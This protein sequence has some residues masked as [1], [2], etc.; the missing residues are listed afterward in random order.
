MSSDPL[1]DEELFWLK[2]VPTAIPS[3]VRVVG[4]I[5][6]GSDICRLR[7]NDSQICKLLRREPADQCSSLLLS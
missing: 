5:L 4:A 3:E 2:L 6:V 7:E 1:T